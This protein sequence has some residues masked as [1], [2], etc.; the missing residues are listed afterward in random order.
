MYTNSRRIVHYV[1]SSST[2][3]R[4]RQTDISMGMTVPAVTSR[5][6][7][8]TS[9]SGWKTSRRRRVDDEAIDERDEIGWVYNYCWRSVSSWSTGMSTWRA[10]ARAPAQE[11]GTRLKRHCAR[12]KLSHCTYCRPYPRILADRLYAN[13]HARPF[14]VTTVQGWSRPLA[15]RSRQSLIL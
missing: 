12:L 6:R 5:Q 9:E 11:G 4:V 3:Q 10:L 15:K 1:T 8:L 14:Y 7:L 2:P 13:V